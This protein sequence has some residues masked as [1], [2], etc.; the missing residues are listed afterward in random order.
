MLNG[1][2]YAIFGV[3]TC[4][5]ETTWKSEC[6]T[7]PA[8]GHLPLLFQSPEPTTWSEVS[9]LEKHVSARRFSR[10]R[11]FTPGRILHITYVKK[12]AT[13][14]KSGIRGSKFAMRWAVAED[15][16]QLAVM[17]R[18]LL[19]HLPENVDKV[20]DTILQQ[21]QELEHQLH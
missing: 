15:F 14:K 6:T 4:D 8:P 3:P 19:D 12:S 5:L 2:G 17:P 7:P 13:D 1:F 18:M 20:L 11:L 10:T 9:V 21:Q 16:M